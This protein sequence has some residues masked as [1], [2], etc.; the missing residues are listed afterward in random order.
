MCNLFETMKINVS[1]PRRLIATL[2]TILLLY[3]PKR[4]KGGVLTLQW[5]PSPHAGYR[6]PVPYLRMVCHMCICVCGVDLCIYIY[7]DLYKKLCIHD[8]D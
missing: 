2:L 1:P 3:L 5:S 7:T 6:G 4:K 8:K